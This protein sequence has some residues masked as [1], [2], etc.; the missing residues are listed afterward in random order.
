MR[1]FQTLWTMN[2]KI[3]H[4]TYPAE[5]DSEGLYIGVPREWKRSDPDRFE[6]VVDELNEL[7]RKTVSVCEEFLTHGRNRF[8]I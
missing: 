5:R 6:R 7:S 4:E 1:L 8:K 2:A 3:V